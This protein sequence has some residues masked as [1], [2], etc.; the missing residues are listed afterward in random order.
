M[1]ENEEN[2]TW[3]LRFIVENRLIIPLA[4][5][6][7]LFLVISSFEYGI[8]ITSDSITYIGCAENLLS[9]DGFTHVVPLATQNHYEEPNYYHEWGPLLPILLSGLMI[10]GLSPELSGLIL[11]FLFYS[12]IPIITLV[13]LYSLE[14]D[15]KYRFAGVILST[16]SLPLF[17]DSSSL[18]SEISFNFF[19]ILSLG[20][21]YYYL[22]EK[23]KRFLHLSILFTSIACLSRFIGITII[24]TGVLLL[25]LLN[26]ESFKKKASE[27]LL[28]G[29]LSSLPTVI[30]LIRNYS[31]TGTLIGDRFGSERG[32]IENLII[33]YTKISEWYIPSQLPAMVWVPISLLFTFTVIFLIISTLK[34]V[35]RKDERKSKIIVTMV[36]FSVIYILYLLTSASNVG[37]TKLTHRFLSPVYIPLVISILVS[38]SIICKDDMKIKK[39]IPNVI[40]IILISGSAISVLAASTGYFEDGT[41]VYSNDRWKTSQTLEYLSENPLEGGVYSNFPHQVYHF[42]G[43]EHAR[44]TPLRNVQG[45]TKEIDGYSLLNESMTESNFIIW[46]EIDRQDRR[47]WLFDIEEIKNVYQLVVLWK[48]S[49]GT[50]YKVEANLSR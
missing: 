43:M 44:Y 38:A 9:G 47:D 29:S 1:V 6:G 30:F 28:F 27:I 19:T 7:P 32:F 10:T 37:F 50:I 24:I 14:I 41:G 49:D 2:K 17:L 23:K 26:R 8:G 33:T 21:L 12:I 22:I 39:I 31:L 13:L 45:S 25:F 42:S 3:F 18:M 36:S 16:L 20:C 15:K 5:I 4:F 46:L 35:F 48:F 11:N 40:V 34:K